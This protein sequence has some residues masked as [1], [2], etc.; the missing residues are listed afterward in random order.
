MARSKEFEINEVLDKAMVLSSDI[1]ES[2]F[3]KEVQ[4][5]LKE[6][7]WQPLIARSSSKVQGAPSFTKKIEFVLS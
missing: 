7:V 5:I 6:A 4:K 1:Q 3:C 2:Y